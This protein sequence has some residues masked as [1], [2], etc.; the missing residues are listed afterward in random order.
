MR[1]LALKAS[2]FLAILTW[3]ITASFIDFS[4]WVI[5]VMNG[6]SM[7]YIIL[8]W[9]ANKKDAPVRRTTSDRGIGSKVS[10]NNLD[11]IVDEKGGDVK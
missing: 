6:L 8:F 1:E 5:P 7:V 2:L 10:M 3:V 9:L 4:S 11:Y